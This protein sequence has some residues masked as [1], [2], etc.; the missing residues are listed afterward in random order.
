VAATN[1]LDF[2]LLIERLGRKYRARVLNSPAGQATTEFR[3]PFSDLELENFLLRVG[4]TRRGVRRIGSPEMEAAKAFGGRL[5]N[6]VFGG[7]VQNCLRSSLDQAS[8]QEAGLRI[9]LRLTDTPEL[10][11]VPW[12]FLYNSALNRFFVLSVETPLVRYLDLPERIRPLAVKPPLKVLV[13]ISNPSDYQ[14]LDVEQEWTKLKKALG[15]ME[16]RGLVTLERLEEATLAALQR[17]LRRGEHH[18]FHFIGHGG[19]DEHAQDGVLLMED[20]A[21]RGRPVSGQDL[22]MLLHDHRPLRLVILNACEGARASRTD[23]FAGTAQSLVQQGITAVIAMQFEITDEAAITLAHE[24]YGAVADG[25]PVDA[26]LAEARKAIFTQG[27]DVEWG[28][29]VLYMRAP[30]G[31]IFSVEVLTPEERA[32]ETARAEA[33]ARARREREEAARVALEQ[34]QTK[35]ATLYEQATTRLAEQD[36]AGACD[37]L[38][39]IQESEPGYR[40]V[41][42]LLYQAR[43]GQVRAAE[44]LAALLARGAEHLGRGEWSLAAEAYR[45]A[46]ALAPGHPQAS[47]RLAE[48]ERQEKASTLFTT[49]QGYLEAGH[50]SEAIAG[51]QAV[52]KLVPTHAEAA[53]QL[54][55]AQA[56]LEQQQAEKR[57]R[58]EEEERQAELARLYTV[59]NEAAQA[60]NWSKAIESFQ[61]VLRLDANYRDAPAGLT[62][63]RAALSAAEAERQR[64]AQLARARQREL[65]EL[66]PPAA[67]PSKLT[68]LLPLLAI[69]LICSVM[70]MATPLPPQTIKIVIALITAVVSVLGI[71]LAWAGHE[72]GRGPK[73]V[74]LVSAIVRLAIAKV[75]R[76][77][78]AK[79]WWGII[80]LGLAIVAMN[81]KAIFTQ[82]RCALG[83]LE[84]QTPG[85][86]VGSFFA[87]L[88]IVV[89]CF[90]PMLSSSQRRVSRLLAGVALVAAVL[91]IGM[92]VQILLPPPSEKECPPIPTPIATATHT[93]TATPTGTLP[94]MPV[95]VRT[96]CA[97]MREI[98]NGNFETG[99]FTFWEHGGDSPQSVVICSQGNYC[100]LLG[101][102]VP[103][104][105]QTTASAWMYQDFVVPNV[106]GTVTVTLSFTYHIA[107]ND[108][109][110]WASF[111]VELR[112]QSDDALVRRVLHDGYS[113]SGRVPIC[114]NDLGWKLFSYS[115]DLSAYKC[116]TIRLYFENRNEWPSSQGIWTYVDDVVL[117]FGP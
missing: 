107:T 51:F 30:D 43:A 61:A 89:G 114:N 74:R 70:V 49:A 7:E 116:K 115:Y 117:R 23:P 106:P 4:R 73:I 108:S 110:D 45:Q 9:R 18:I 100:A 55:E 113:V 59:A 36:W 98:Q 5:F 104:I 95:V 37:L 82:F 79:V 83:H 87:L 96:D 50:W 6:A 102:P 26:A 57:R 28:T 47:A 68:L 105:S 109:I 58:H 52:L 13:M 8:R 65:V 12:E 99:N 88:A 72:L 19:F 11:D 20:Q 3:L 76:G 17:W 44:Q 80:G 92:L 86:T 2:D 101:E 103:C 34:R 111:Y 27:N 91:L 97:S 16:Q 33:E 63:A 71:G 46:L 81:I 54:D 29:P 90:V 66:S 40:D 41:A 10:A 32:A 64:K 42:A 69:F 14:Q 67:K 94:G 77:I 93:A 39:Q 60:K 75:R 25:Y 78:P 112:D 31:R 48:A 24:F 56:Q 1:Y 84:Y 35:L 85:L 62:Q 53:Q 38:A 15:D 21:G 22:G